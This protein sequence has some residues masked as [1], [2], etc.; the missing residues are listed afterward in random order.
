MI[1]NIIFDLGDV[2]VYP[3]SGNWFITN[4]FYSIVDKNFINTKKLAK[5]LKGNLYLNTQE[6]KNEQEEH[7][8]FA[9]YYYKVLEDMDYPSLTLDIAKKLA[10]DCVYNDAKFI[11]YD[12]VKSTLEDMAKKYNLYIISNGWPSSLRI[13]HNNDLEKHFKGIFIS[14]MYGTIKEEKLFDIFLDKYKLDARESI[15]IDD[16]KRILD[17]AKEYEFKLLLMDR[18]AKNKFSEYK[19]IN[20]LDEILK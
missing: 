16:R 18:N 13:L 14:S 1:K 4:N 3:K 20:S 19:T 8:M 10:D 2:L 6:P 9:N 7:D 17:K 12:D 11:F 5:V 15:Y